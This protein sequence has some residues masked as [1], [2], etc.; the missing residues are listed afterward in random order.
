MPWVPGYDPMVPGEAIHAPGDLPGP[1]LGIFYSPALEK[2][3]V[4]SKIENASKDN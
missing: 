4:C 2:M 3:L 1:Q